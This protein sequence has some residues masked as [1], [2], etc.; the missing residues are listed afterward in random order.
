LGDVE[1]SGEVTVTDLLPAHITVSG[2]GS[3]QVLASD[4]R[5]VC[6]LTGQSVFCS[7]T[8]PIP[9]NGVAIP[10]ASLEVYATSGTSANNGAVVN[11]STGATVS[12]TWTTTLVD[13]DTRRAKVRARAGG[14][15]SAPVGVPFNWSMGLM[16]SVPRV[17]T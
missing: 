3:G 2:I 8:D 11:W 12:P 9:A 5:F 10:V 1:T 6:T 13:T 15:A 7:T 16:A 14:V 17:P 4:P